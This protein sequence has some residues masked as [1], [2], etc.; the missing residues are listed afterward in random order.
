[1]YC[2]LFFYRRRKIKLDIILLFEEEVH[3]LHVKT[4]KLLPLSCNTYKMN[5][6]SFI[7]PPVDLRAEIQSLFP[8]IPKEIFYRL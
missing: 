3:P 5:A 4:M 7:A 2:Y 8:K 1:M 6:L